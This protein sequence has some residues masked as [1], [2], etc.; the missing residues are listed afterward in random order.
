MLK[1]TI[2]LKNSRPSEIG[3]GEIYQANSAVRV[4]PVA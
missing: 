4:G 2:S 3:Q 1:H